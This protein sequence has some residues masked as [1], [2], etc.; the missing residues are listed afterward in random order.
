MT[1]GSSYDYPAQRA[2]RLSAAKQLQKAGPWGGRFPNPPDLNFDYRRLVGQQGGVAKASASNHRICIIGAGITGLTTARELFRCGYNNISIFEARNR[3]AGRHHTITD[4]ANQGLALQYSPFE[5]AAMRMPYFNIAGEA[6]NDG[7]SLLA[8]YAKEFGLSIQNFPNPGTPWVTSTGI[9]LQ[10]GLVQGG[11]T[12]TMQVWVNSTGST[13]PPTTQLQAVYAKWKKFETLMVDVVST[14][15]GSAG[16]ENLWQAIVNRYQDVAFRAFVRMDAINA[17]SSANPGNFGGLGMTEDESN[18]FYA[19]G[20]GDGSWG[21]FYDVSTIYPLRTAIFGFGSQLQL[22]HGRYNS[23]GTFNPGPNAN[24]PTVPDSLLR[25]F[26]GPKYRGVR[27][28]D[29]CML[30]LDVPERGTS[31]YEWSHMQDNTRGNIATQRMVRRL[32][33]EN[34]GIRVYYT[35]GNNSTESSEVFDSVVMTVPSWIMEVDMRLEGFSLEEIPRKVTMAYKTAHWETSCKIYAPL[36]PSFF[37]DSNNRIPPILVT[38]TFVHDVYAYQYSVGNYQVPCI[39]IS[40]TWEDDATKLASF[41]D[42]VLV[43]KCI[44]ELDRILLRSQNIGQRISPYIQSRD[45]QVVRWITEP[46]SLGCAKL[47]RPGTYS[48]AMSLLA[49][50]REYAAKS[51]LYLA[52]ESF[53]VDAGWTEPS[54]RGAIDTVINICNNTG[55]TFNGGF[56]MADYPRYRV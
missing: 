56:T 1:I 41:S 42:D 15:Y 28:F 31:F 23:D 16:W 50:N 44:E 48:E 2:E 49:Y 52:G 47:Y 21:A 43:G 29:D 39:L 3:I 20:F 8:Y 46:S 13:P 4:V 30:F 24:S 25:Q 26:D 19:I 40:Y 10:E 33:K 37:T 32:V 38:D 17:W 53:S 36:S 9:Y 11:N 51:G 18:I 12:P 7:Q 5:M 45:A 55:A 27:S 35:D 22:I 6:P 54:F 14:Q 34:A